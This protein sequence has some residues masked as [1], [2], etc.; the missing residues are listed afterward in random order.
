MTTHHARKFPV[1]LL[2]G[3][4]GSGKSTHAQLLAATSSIPLKHL[5]VGE[6]V[7]EHGLHEGWDEEWKSWTVDE[8]RVGLK[9]IIS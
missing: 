3:T 7:K 2:T 4:P 5:N 6:L 9:Y 1:I 8:D